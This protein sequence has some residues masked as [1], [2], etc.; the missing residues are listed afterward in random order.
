MESPDVGSRGHVLGTR[1][2]TAWQDHIGIRLLRV[3]GPSM[4][5]LECQDEESDLVFPEAP[6]SH[7]RL[8]SR[9]GPWCHSGSARR[10]GCGGGAG[11][12]GDQ[13]AGFLGQ[14]QRKTARCEPRQDGVDQ[15]NR[16]RGCPSGKDSTCQC[17]RH[18]DSVPDPG[19]FQVPRSNSAHGP[20][21]LSLH[22]TPR[23]A[24]VMRSPRTA[25]RA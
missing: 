11:R 8:L 12:Q 23:E 10:T 24:T 25:T 2:G 20:Q 6:R 3:S 9:K 22:S 5:S 1:R 16:G 15:E 13:E 17:K 7:A 14:S 21:L 18:T 4:R 19:R